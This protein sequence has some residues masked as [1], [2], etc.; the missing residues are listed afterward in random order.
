MVWEQFPL[1]I[2]K[3]NKGCASNIIL[4]T[5]SLIQTRI[6][7]N[8]SLLVYEGKSRDIV[9]SSHPQWRHFHNWRFSLALLYLTLPQIW[10]P[11]TEPF[12]LCFPLWRNACWWNF[13]DGYPWM[14][15]LMKWEMSQ[16][17]GQMLKALGTSKADCN[18]ML[19]RLKERS[20]GRGPSTVY[21]HHPDKQSQGKCGSQHRGPLANML[22]GIWVLKNIS[23]KEK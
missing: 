8:A 7:R 19:H 21:R 11:S 5:L 14:H 6:E 23:W 15:F 10:L 9:Y 22:H 16:L 20:G 4:L 2:W 17:P 3:T 13:L 1:R 18:S 12:L